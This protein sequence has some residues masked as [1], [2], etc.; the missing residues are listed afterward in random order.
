MPGRKFLDF[1]RRQ[2]SKKLLGKF[3]EKGI[4]QTI[5][6]LEMLEQQNQ[7]L[8]VAGLELSIDAIERMSDRVGDVGAGKVPLERKNVVTNYRNIGVLLL[9]NSPYQDM[10]FAR[11]LREISRNLLTYER[12][13]QIADLETPVDRVVVRDRDEIHSSLDEL[14]VELAGIGITIRKIQP[15]EKPF[16]RTG[17]EPGVNV[18]IALAHI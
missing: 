8:D 11:I 2:R 15:A 6:P 3:A 10:N 12:V 1:L 5:G 18:K 9:G 17:A 14:P 7:A 16:L 13:G 4:A